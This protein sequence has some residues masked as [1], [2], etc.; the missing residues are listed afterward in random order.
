MA[1]IRKS[2][3]GWKPSDSDQVVGYKLYWSKEDTVNYDCNFIEL[4]DVT[5]VCLPDV[6]KDVRLNDEPIMLGITAMDEKG[7]ESDI[8]T[9]PEPYQPMAPLGPVDLLLTI[10]DDFNVI[11]PGQQALDHFD[12]L[13]EEDT[14]D[15]E[16]EELGRMAEPL[17]RS[18]P[19]EEKAKYYDDIGYRGPVIDK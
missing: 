10:L 9:L 5:E 18:E 12:S 19:R 2:K 14:H 1:K 16:L 15:E 11:D 7:N 3:L 6:L 8:V 4:G 13:I 17:I